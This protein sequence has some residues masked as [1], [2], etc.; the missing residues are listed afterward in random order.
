MTPVQIW[1][2]IFGFVSASGAALNNYIVLSGFVQESFL[3]V[4]SASAA[5]LLF[6][7]WPW[8]E[9]A[10]E[11]GFNRPVE[12]A[13]NPFWRFRYAIA[14]LVAYAAL[15][16]VYVWEI[17]FRATQ[18]KVIYP[19]PR[20]THQLMDM[21]FTRAAARENSLKLV[22]FGLSSN[23]T[24]SLRLLIQKQSQKPRRTA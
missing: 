20:E 24:R 8:K 18:G 6:S 5:V 7:I 11:V 12:T 15:T 23:R 2:A 1:L 14:V 19:N 21:F 13:S 16:G 17:K 4:F 22:R 3:I 9:P 10:F